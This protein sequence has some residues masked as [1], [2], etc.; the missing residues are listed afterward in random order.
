MAAAFYTAATILLSAS[1]LAVVIV[2]HTVILD[3]RYDLIKLCEC[4]TYIAVC[5]SVVDC[6][7]STLG[8]MDGCTWE[9][10]V[11]NEASLLIPLFRCK[12]EVLT[13]IQY[14]GRI[15][16]IEDRSTD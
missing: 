14:L 12:K 4:K 6:D 10:Y 1:D 15:L 9:G 8:V 11:W 3:I 2:G 13:T 7:L 5:A 16:K